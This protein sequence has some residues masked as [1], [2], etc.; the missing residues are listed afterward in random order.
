MPPS[1]G[2]AG[3]TR[4]TPIVLLALAG[5][6]LLARI[7]VGVRDVVS[8]ESRPELVDWVS[9]AE[10]TQPGHP[11]GHLMLY[12]FTDHAQA[13]SRKLA[14]ELFASPAASGAINREFVPVR[15]EGDPSADD[16]ATRALRERF[17]VGELPALV[18]ATPDGSRF[19]TIPAPAN[20]RDALQA[21]K[22]AQMEVMGLPFGATKGFQFR[23]GNSGASGGPIGGPPN[24]GPGAQVDSVA[25]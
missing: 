16:P 4:T 24:G 8:P 19:K 20:A 7:G 5:L 22:Q 15:I 21:I 23:I 10:A 14:S 25:K 3:P 2:H 6:L 1:N 12:A 18:V 13:A 17:K 11:S 9:V